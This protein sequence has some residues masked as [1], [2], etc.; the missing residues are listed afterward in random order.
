MGK[1]DICLRAARLHVMDVLALSICLA[2]LGVFVVY[3]C[4]RTLV[5]AALVWDVGVLTGD[6]GYVPIRNTLLISLASVV[7]SGLVGTGFALFLNRYVFPGSRLLG[8]LAYLP[9][10]LPPL[11]GVVAFYYLIGRDGLIPLFLERCLGWRNAFPHG[12]AAILLIHTYSFYVFFYA[13]VGPALAGMDASLAEAARSLGAS[14]WRAF[15]TVTLPLLRPALV[16]ASLLTFMSSAASFSAPLLFGRDFPMLSVRIYEA[17]TQFNERES[18]VLTVV[19]ALVSLAGILLFRSRSITA[20]GASK[21]APRAMRSRAARAMAAWAAACVTIALLAPHGTILWMSFVDHARWR[22]ELL[23]TVFTLANYTEIL[24]DPRALEPI[25][26]SLW[27][28]GVG[29]VLAVLAGLPAGYLIGRKRA[30]HRWVS[31]VTVIPWALPGTVVAMSLLT[32][33]NDPWMPR[34]T[35]LWLLPLAYFVRGVPLFTRMA[36][37]AI[38]PFDARL[39][40]AGRTLGAGPWRVGWTVAAPLLAPALLAAVSLVFATSLGEFVASIL[41]YRPSN[42]PIAVKINME[43]RGANIGSAFAYSVF[44]MAL[45]GVTF[46]GARR[47]AGRIV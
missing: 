16:G 6:D 18:L 2:L 47:F 24:H 9:F 19:L 15:R 33:F 34:N 28:S 22:T 4:L 26:N 5:R 8:V 30:G 43:L 31:L 12:P 36:T 46:A 3:P 40:E 42:I 27:M 7:S 32:A 13:M 14:R 38:E 29:S 11:V 1:R 20:G 17:N 37:A 25:R 23:P 10:T 39:I 44:L 35:V 45:V 21:G 41:L